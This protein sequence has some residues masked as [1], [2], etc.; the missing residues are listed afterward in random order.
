MNEKKDNSR[1]SLLLMSI[2]HCF[3]HFIDQRNDQ[4]Q[5]LIAW[6]SWETPL[7]W[8]NHHITA[9][10]LKWKLVCQERAHQIAGV[11]SQP[12]Q[13]EPDRKGAVH[14]PCFTWAV[15]L[16]A[17]GKKNRQN[18]TWCLHKR[19]FPLRD[20]NTNTYGSEDTMKQRMDRRPR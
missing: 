10:H 12:Q 8:G 1:F 3:W 16:T 4:K 17:M 5:W 6:V 15:I 7:H 13:Q 14:I 19:A 18:Y 11:T 2:C 9:S 20:N